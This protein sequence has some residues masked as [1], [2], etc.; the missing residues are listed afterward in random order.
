MIK[1]VLKLKENQS[2]KS[3]PL[4]ESVKTRVYYQPDGLQGKELLQKFSN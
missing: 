2:T 3:I 1:L 4:E